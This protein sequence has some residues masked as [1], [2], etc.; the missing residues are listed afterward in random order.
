[1][2]PFAFSTPA[3]LQPYVLFDGCI[4]KTERHNANVDG[5]DMRSQWTPRS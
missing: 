1:M 2:T 5:E 4:R 3:H